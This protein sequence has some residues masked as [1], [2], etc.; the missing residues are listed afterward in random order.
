MPG[1]PH[2]PTGRNNTDHVNIYY[3]RSTC[4]KMD[5]T[6][7]YVSP[8]TRTWDEVYTIMLNEE[9][10]F[11]ILRKVRTNNYCETLQQDLDTL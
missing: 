3:S 6:E 8:K 11:K 4:A 10:I 7:M 1:L 9:K 2:T 5:F